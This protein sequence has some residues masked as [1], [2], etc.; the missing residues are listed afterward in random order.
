MREQ[1]REKKIVKGEKKQKDE[2]KSGSST[3]RSAYAYAVS[4]VSNPGEG[5]TRGRSGR[6]RCNHQCAREFLMD[7]TKKKI[8]RKN[9]LPPL[10]GQRTKKRFIAIRIKSNF[11]L[12]FLSDFTT[13]SNVHRFP[14]AQWIRIWITRLPIIILA[15]CKKKN[16]EPV[17][18]LIGRS[19]DTIVNGDRTNHRVLS[20][21]I[22]INA[23]ETR[24]SPLRAWT[25]MKPL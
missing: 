20:V 5:L 3:C 25:T 19:V 12:F 15:R 4:R 6:A 8:G 23:Q 18:T 22:V 17:F 7:G 9:L 21:S 24:W 13:I 1:Q 10:I 11:E 16:L 14:F 2:E